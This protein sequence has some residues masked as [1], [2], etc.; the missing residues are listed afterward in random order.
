MCEHD[1][2]ERCGEATFEVDEEEAFFTNEI[3]WGHF[4]MLAKSATDPANLA[5]SGWI[6]YGEFVQRNHHMSESSL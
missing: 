2:D 4:S 1:E 5:L 6:R 3:S